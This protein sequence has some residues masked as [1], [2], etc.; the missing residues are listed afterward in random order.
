MQLCLLFLGLAIGHALGQQ[1]FLTWNTNGARWDAVVNYLNHA[2]VL[3]IQEAGTLQPQL[4]AAPGQIPHPFDSIV[5]ENANIQIAHVNLATGEITET[6]YNGGVTLYK[7]VVQG[8][9]YF[10][11]Y[12]ERIVDNPNMQALNRDTR[13]QNMAIIS[14]VRAQKVYV[15]APHSRDA[16]RVDVNRPILGISIPGYMVFSVHTDP[17]ASNEINETITIINTY[18]SNDCR[19]ERWILMGDFNAQPNEIS[20]PSASTGCY[21]QLVYPA[22]P[23]KPQRGRVIDYAICGGPISWNTNIQAVT[24]PNLLGSDHFP[25]IIQSVVNRIQG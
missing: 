22:Q 8:R 13:K 16:N 18:M 4:L 15:F 1:R 10:M 14:T 5:R 11:Y 2:D 19:L 12:Y 21:L 7:I 25:V 3:A 9:T 6:R 17:L 20:V 23:T 24:Q